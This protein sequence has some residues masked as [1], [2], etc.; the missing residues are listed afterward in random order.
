[1]QEFCWQS[2]NPGKTSNF[3]PAAEGTWR[4]IVSGDSRNCGDVVMPAIAAQGIERYQPS[5]YWHWVI[6]V[7]YKVDE[8]M[9]AAAKK[10]ASPLELYYRRAWQ[11][12]I[13]H[14][15]VPFGTTRF[16]L[17]IG[18]H[19]VIPPKTPWIFRNFKTGC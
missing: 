16:Y 5:F 2:R 7:I 6:F 4:F 3:I 14:Q 12:F 19:E 17:G 13:D 11:D 18:N 10:M 15:I 9:V 1:M 8:D